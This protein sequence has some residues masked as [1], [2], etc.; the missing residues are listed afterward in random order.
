MPTPRPPETFVIRLFARN[1]SPFTDAWIPVW[2]TLIVFR[3]ICALDSES[4]IPMTT[5]LIWLSA[6][7]GLARTTPMPIVAVVI[8]LKDRLGHGGSMMTRG[9]AKRSNVFH[10]TDPLPVTLNWTPVGGSRTTVLFPTH[11]VGVAC[12]ASATRRPSTKRDLPGSTR[13]FT[14]GLIVRVTPGSTVTCCVRV[15]VLSVLPHV[16]TTEMKPRTYVI[17]DARGVTARNAPNG[18]P[19]TARTATRLRTRALLGAYMGRDLSEPT[20]GVRPIPRS[21]ESL[22]IT[23]GAVIGRDNARACPGCPRPPSVGNR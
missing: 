11:R 7:V 12:A 5:L 4:P 13:T 19:T 9:R 8:V 6:T 18:T 23:N 3:R 17:A 2:A 10:D 16:V 20:G 21:H 22:Y 14:P 15:Y 1:G